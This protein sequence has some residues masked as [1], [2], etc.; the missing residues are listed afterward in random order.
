MGGE[1]DDRGC[2]GYMASLTQWKCLSKLAGVGHGQGGVAFCS[3]CSLK[4]SDMTEQL[5]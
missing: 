5:N 1:G 4:E 2:D 3:P